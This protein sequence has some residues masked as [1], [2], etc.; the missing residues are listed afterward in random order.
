[1]GARFTSLGLAIRTQAVLTE[2]S[3]RDWHFGGKQAEQLD[4]I[5]FLLLYPFRM[6]TR[7]CGITVMALGPCQV[8]TTTDSA[9]SSRMVSSSSATTI[10]LHGYPNFSQSQSEMSLERQQQ[11]PRDGAG[12]QV[13]QPSDQTHQLWQNSY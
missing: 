4:D 3:E 6:K 9:S 1:M 10:A 13:G 11:N 5:V 12:A 2:F 8:S 7:Q